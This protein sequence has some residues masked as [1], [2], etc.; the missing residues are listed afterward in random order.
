M[1]IISDELFTALI[2]LLSQDP[3]VQIFKELLTAEKAEPVEKPAEPQE[4]K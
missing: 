4:V 3:K 2:K 1:R